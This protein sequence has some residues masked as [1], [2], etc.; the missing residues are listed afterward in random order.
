MQGPTTR[1]TTTALALAALLALTA[2]TVHAA[3]TEGEKVGAGFL[4]IMLT[5]LTPELRTHFGV[6]EDA[7]VL[8]AKVIDD[9][10]A[11]RAGLQVGDVITLVD[12][13]SVASGGELARQ[14]AGHAAGETVA[15]EVWRDGRAQRLGAT[16]EERQGTAGRFLPLGPRFHLR[17]GDGPMRRIEVIC[18]DGDCS[19]RHART[20]D[21]DCDGADECEIRVL[22]E[23]GACS[24]T[25]NG[26]DADCKAIGM[27]GH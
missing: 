16:L 3:E 20:S 24:C 26:E 19:D 22:C 13:E 15:L 9:S 2:A 5:D 1:H 18:R 6:P 21:F 4:G 23:D 10:P 17:H 12:A 7:G 14:I 25:V 27:P 8:V 11:Q